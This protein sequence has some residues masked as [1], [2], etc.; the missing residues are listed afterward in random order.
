MH[1]QLPT[2][3]RAPT[4]LL[5]TPVAVASGLAHLLDAPFVV[6]DSLAAVFVANWIG[7]CILLV[8]TRVIRSRW[9]GRPDEYPPS[10]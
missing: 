10:R 2:A 4:S 1:E 6:Y 5:L 9:R 7:W 8:G 3:I